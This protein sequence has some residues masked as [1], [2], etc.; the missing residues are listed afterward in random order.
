MR[1]IIP[2]I[3]GLAFATA[4]LQP[5][6][7]TAAEP[8]AKPS[9]GKLKA[10]VKPEEGDHLHQGQADHELHGLGPGQ[11][12]VLQEQQVVPGVCPLHSAPRS[13]PRE[14]ERP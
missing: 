13:T 6:Q 5:T 10:D 2:V 9:A 7:G 3:L 4:A 8:K 12:L 1:F 11:G 14:G